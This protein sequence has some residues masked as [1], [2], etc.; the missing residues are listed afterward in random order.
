MIKIMDA[1]NYNITH[2]TLH[3]FFIINYTCEYLSYITPLYF[4]YIMLLY[5][6]HKITFY[7]L[8]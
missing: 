8:C 3:I 5:K 6:S 2:I 7:P 1:F 4:L